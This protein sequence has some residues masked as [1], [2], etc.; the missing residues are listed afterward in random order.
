MALSGDDSSHGQQLIAT[1][2]CRMVVTLR[3]VSV[4]DIGQAPGDL[5]TLQA[6]VNTLDI[7]QGADLL[8][9]PAELD[10]WL[11]SAGL[12]DRRAQGSSPADLAHA[13]ELREA[14]RAVLASHVAHRADR[15]V[16]P[17]NQA[18]GSADPAARLAA[19]A[20]AARAVIQVDTAGRVVLAPAE[21]G[22]RAGLTCL[23][24]IA[25][26]AATRGTWAR[27]KVC[28]ADDCQWAFYDR[29][30][31]RTG[32]WCSMQICGSRAKSRAYRD[33]AARQPAR[34]TLP[35]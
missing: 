21:S 23:L 10:E 12:V 22:G 11:L 33:R 15:L 31:A 18:S 29:S 34:A 6:F 1:S 32:C 14:L 3:R 35:T 13:V 25:A 8:S 9:T 28:S 19:V 30:P 4:P 2:R 24:L 7:E 26:D 17:P 20:A 16:S 5:S 27:L